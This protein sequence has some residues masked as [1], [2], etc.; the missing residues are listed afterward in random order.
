MAIP[1]RRTAGRKM[2]ISK[3]TLAEQPLQT[4]ILVVADRTKTDSHTLRS[5]CGKEQLKMIQF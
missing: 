5:V 1:L 3:A 2:A 4:K